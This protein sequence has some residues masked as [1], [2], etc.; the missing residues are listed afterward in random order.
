MNVIHDEYASNSYETLIN[1]CEV[2]D[3]D[4]NVVVTCSNGSVI[5][6]ADVESVLDLDDSLMSKENDVSILNDTEV[7]SNSGVDYSMNDNANSVSISNVKGI[8]KLYPSNMIVSHLNVNSL[9]RKFDEVSNMIVCSGFEV[10]ALSE[11]KLDSSFQTSLYE[12][13]NYV[14]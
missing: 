12:I 8:R 13:E 1:D 11:T 6:D 3:T 9:S 2:R 7:Q 10:V 4:D 14:M 5:S